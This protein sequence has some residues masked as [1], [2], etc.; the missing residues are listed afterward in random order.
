MLWKMT[1][2]YAYS[3]LHLASVKLTYIYVW[4]PNL[5]YAFMTWCLSVKNFK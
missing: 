3:H 2:L 1:E 5:T 4:L